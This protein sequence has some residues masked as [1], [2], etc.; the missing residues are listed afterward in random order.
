[1]LVTEVGARV[2]GDAL[3]VAEQTELKA[4]ALTTIPVKP[5]GGYRFV[6]T[7]GE[8]DDQT[9]GVVFIY[10][11]K[12]DQDGIEGIFERVLTVPGSK[13]DGSF[14]TTCTFTLHYN[15]MDRIF[16]LEY[17]KPA[18][19]TSPPEYG[20]YQLVEDLTERYQAAYPQVE[21]VYTSQLIGSMTA[22]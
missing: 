17:S 3:T 12:Y 20:V 7:R 22:E 21:Q 9:E 16:S 10:P 11:E 18:V 4:K 1:M 13:D 6:Y 2:A 19:K 8:A 15:G 14:Y 5:G